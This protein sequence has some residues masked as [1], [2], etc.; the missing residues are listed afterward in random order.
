MFSYTELAL[1]L[2]ISSSLI[3]FIFNRIL[4]GLEGQMIKLKLFLP[5]NMK[6]GLLG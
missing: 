6:R 2:P 4:S 5:L 3:S 1:M